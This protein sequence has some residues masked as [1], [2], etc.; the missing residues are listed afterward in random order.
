MLLHHYFDAKTPLRAE[1]SLSVMIQCIFH[2]TTFSPV[3][4]LCFYP[5]ETE[6][7]CALFRFSPCHF[8]SFSDSAWQR[9]P[10][11][12]HF[13]LWRAIT[14]EIEPQ[15]A[16]TLKAS[17]WNFERKTHSCYVRVISSYNNHTWQDSILI[18]NLFK[19][20]SSKKVKSRLF[21]FWFVVVFFFEKGTEHLILA[22]FFL[23]KTFIFKGLYNS[24]CKHSHTG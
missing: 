14:T 21:F 9:T 12:N 8:W 23:L 6:A 22:D 1:S 7:I 17:N 18:Q 15:P 3:V 2:W 19:I 20:F 13:R 24:V 4:Q 11:R 5:A 16:V 10:G